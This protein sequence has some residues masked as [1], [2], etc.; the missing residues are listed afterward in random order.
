MS[1]GGTASDFDSGLDFD[2]ELG[3]DLELD[4]DRDL[5][6]E[7]DPEPD[8]DAEPG[9]GGAAGTSRTVSIGVLSGLSPWKLGCRSFPSLVHSVKLTCATSRGLTQRASRI[10]GAPRTC[11]SFTSS[12]RSSSS[13]SLRIFEEKPVPTLP[14]YSSVP[15]SFTP[16][17]SAPIP[18]EAAPSPGVQPTIASSC[19]RCALIFIQSLLRPFW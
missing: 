5:D 18:L 15:P 13:S 17:S 10:R 8:R 12:L 19:D 6:P 1:A 14:A 4:P 2:L 9:L 11:G 7:P 16:S 3:L